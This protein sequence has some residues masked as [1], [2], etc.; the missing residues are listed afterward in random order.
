MGTCGRIV[1]LFFSCS[2]SSMMNRRV[3]QPGES[4]G[5]VAESA[6]PGCAWATDSLWSPPDDIESK[7]NSVYSLAKYVD[8]VLLRK[9]T[10]VLW[11]VLGLA[12][13]SSFSFLS[14]LG[15]S[16]CPVTSSTSSTLRFRPACR[17]GL[18]GS[19][20][21]M[22]VDATTETCGPDPAVDWS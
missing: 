4:S 21:G 18:R 1:P 11:R 19:A 5:S 7:V 17:W 3:C 14:F 10:T 15:C 9:D 8:A 2:F 22:A 20:T 12:T 6:R 16:A 13:T